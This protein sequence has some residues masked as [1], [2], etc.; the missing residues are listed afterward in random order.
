ME[1]AQFAPQLD[2]G[3]APVIEEWNR[4]CGQKKTVSIDTICQAKGVD[5]FHF[6]GVVCEAAV[7]YR[8]NASLIIAALS[9]PNVI[10][11]SVKT[12]LTKDGFKDRELLAK[13][14]GF[15][16]VP[17]GATFVNTFAAKVEQNNEGGTPGATIP[18]F[19]NTIEAVDVETV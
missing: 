3:C 19:E 17:A 12:A 13:H 16:P 15:I 9:M 10:E 18:S 8:D 2:Q 7:K 5:P 1:L 11:R 14:S 6:L 4:L